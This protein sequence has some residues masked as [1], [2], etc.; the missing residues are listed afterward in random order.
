[1]ITKNIDILNFLRNTCH[2]YGQTNGDNFSRRLMETKQNNY[3]FLVSSGDHALLK[4]KDAFVD[5]SYDN[6]RFKEFN[7]LD[8]TNMFTI[9]LSGRDDKSIYGNIAKVKYQ[10]FYK[11]VKE[12]EQPVERVAFNKNG[13]VM[14][15]HVNYVSL[16]NIE[17]A[18]LARY[19][20]VE[21]ISANDEGIIATIEYIKGLINTQ[22][23]TVDEST[24]LDK[25]K[26]QADIKPKIEVVIIKPGGRP[27]VDVIVNDIPSFQRKVNGLIRSIPDAVDKNSIIICNDNDKQYNFKPN[28]RINGEIIHGTIVI[29]G[30]D[31]ETGEFA[32]LS[33]DQQKQYVDKYRSRDAAK[34]TR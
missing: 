8:D 5:G 25:V 24:F 7:E 31:N 12:Y 33:K 30:F 4:A 19:D 15:T 22:L 3:F 10:Q 18:D 2:I 34:D 11:L 32:S 6:W 23:K 21:S 29:A 28:R 16:D 9:E 13:S 17:L 26:E 14:T 1:M 27:Y 20:V